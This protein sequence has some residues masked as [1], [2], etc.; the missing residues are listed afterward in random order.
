MAKEL[1]IFGKS[2]FKTT[3]R[4]STWVTSV[5][6]CKNLPSFD[7][8]HYWRT[9]VDGQTVITV[10][11]IS[12]FGKTV[13]TVSRISAFGQTVIT[14]SRISAFATP[15]RNVGPLR[16]YRYWWSIVWRSNVPPKLQTYM[17]AHMCMHACEYV[18]GCFFGYMYVCIGMFM[19]INMHASA[20]TCMHVIVY[21][22]E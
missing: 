10:S 8:D 20:Y 21:L 2:K 7:Q 5:R 14:V 6:L 9:N 18:H 19:Y 13:I 1:Q 11:R 17:P 22:R 4:D 12:A 15:S 3:P 16:S